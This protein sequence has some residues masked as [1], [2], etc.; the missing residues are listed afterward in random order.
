[1]AVGMKHFWAKYKLVFWNNSHDSK[2]LPVKYSQSKEDFSLKWPTL[3]SFL[4]VSTGS[5]Q[6]KI[7]A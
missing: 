4:N 2:K 5:S 1:M 3:V 6:S 7:L